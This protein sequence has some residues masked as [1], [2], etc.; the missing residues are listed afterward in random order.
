[1]R[2]NITQTANIQMEDWDAYDRT[3]YDGDITTS[4]EDWKLD[5]Y[6][7]FLRPKEGRY[8]RT[9]GVA[10][11]R[12]PSPLTMK[13]EVCFPV[14]ILSGTMDNIIYKED[15]SLSTLKDGELFWERVNDYLNENVS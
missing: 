13:V 3:Y 6:L 8:N 14:R 15:V 2:L 1:M 11:H 7:Y 5:W 9:V 4:S 10:I 12:N